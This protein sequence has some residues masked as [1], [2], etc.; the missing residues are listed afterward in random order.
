MIC[1]AKINHQKPQLHL[2]A[3]VSNVQSQINT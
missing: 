3:Q 1:Q 2:V